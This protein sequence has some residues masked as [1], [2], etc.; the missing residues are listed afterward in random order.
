MT[1][2]SGP[3]FAVADQSKA[4]VTFVRTQGAKEQER[5]EAL[6][7][8]ARRNRINAQGEEA[9]VGKPE[10]G[11]LCDGGGPEP[12]EAI[13]VWAGC[14]ADNR[15]SDLAGV[16]RAQDPGAPLGRSRKGLWEQVG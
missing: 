7:E 10:P 16:A 12:R 1:A 11:Q 6:L 14:L 3:V 15:V 13:G 2:G 8:E 4:S 9:W 5:N